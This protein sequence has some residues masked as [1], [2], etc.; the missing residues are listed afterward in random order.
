MP[1]WQP[2]LVDAA[3]HGVGRVVDIAQFVAHDLSHQV[4]GGS[5]RKAVVG[6]EPVEHV[7]GGVLQRL[8]ERTG[9]ADRIDGLG[10]FA[11]RPDQRFALFQRQPDFDLVAGLDA[12]ADDLAVTLDGV[13]IAK[14]EQ[15]TRHGDGEPDG[16]A[17]AEA[18][19]RAHVG[20]ALSARNIAAHIERE[21]LDKPKDWKPLV[22]CWRGGNR[23]GALATILGAIGFQ[24]TLI[25]GGYKAWRAALVDDLPALASRLQYR[26][27]CGPTGSGKTTMINLL[28][29]HY[30][31]TGGKITIDGHDL[32]DID[33]MSLRRQIG[34]VL[35]ESLLFH[36]SIRENLRYG[37]IGA[38]DADIVAAATAA[39][40]HHVIEAFP[41]GYD[42]KIGEEGVKLSGGE[43]QRLAIARA[44]LADPRILVLDEATSSLDSETEALIQEALDRLMEGRTSF[45]IAHRLS[46]IVKANKIVVMEK[47]TIVEL[48]S[49]AELLEQGGNYARLYAEQ[50]RA[51][52][53]ASGVG[54]A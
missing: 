20:A 15:R 50:F 39:N 34:V 21:V 3:D 38:S 37:R 14:K 27:V 8:V 19:M 41:D 40:L 24:V 49:H 11:A 42:T 47:G 7:G 36:T 30:D 5:G 26:V 23:S 46:T 2:F 22:Y 29:R 48:G 53:E 18:A 13:A 32:R 10:A 9:I 6:A 28:S 17:G 52:L 45:V 1:F 12:G 44:L 35:Q 16:R 25:E 43:K 33:L 4:A 54:D 51:E 31:V